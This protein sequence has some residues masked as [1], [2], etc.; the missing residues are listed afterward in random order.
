MRAPEEPLELMA[1]AI[2]AQPPIISIPSTIKLP[3]LKI[4]LAHSKAM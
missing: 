1:C 3:N 2:P 4:Y